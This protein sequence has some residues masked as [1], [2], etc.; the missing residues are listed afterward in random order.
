MPP[1]WYRMAHFLMVD[2]TNVFSVPSGSVYYADGFGC[3]LAQPL[4]VVRQVEEAQQGFE[5]GRY[6]I[7][8]WISVLRP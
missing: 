2:A 3:D 4:P 7:L 1:V 6:L 5:A 8:L